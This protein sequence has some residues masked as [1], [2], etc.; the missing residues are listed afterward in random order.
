MTAL[1][2]VEEKILEDLIHEVIYER[3]NDKKN[4]ERSND[5]IDKII[6]ATDKEIPSVKDFLA[7]SS[8]KSSSTVPDKQVGAEQQELPPLD[9]N[10]PPKNQRRPSFPNRSNQQVPLLIGNPNELNCRHFMVTRQS[11]NTFGLRSK[12]S[13]T[14]LTSR[15]NKR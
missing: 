1:E 8:R 7:C 5:E 10:L 12:V 15:R 2:N 11:S 9:C 14:I 3:A 6:D 4:V 13:W